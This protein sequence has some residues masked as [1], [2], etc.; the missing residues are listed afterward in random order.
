MVISIRSTECVRCRE[1][2]RFWEGPLSETAVESPRSGL[3]PVEGI[4]PY[5]LSNNY[6]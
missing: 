3:P 1:A 4:I 6:A 2:V 5:S